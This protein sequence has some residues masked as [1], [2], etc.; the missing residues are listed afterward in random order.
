MTDEPAAST[1]GRLVMGAQVSQAISVAAAMGSADLLSDGPPTSEELAVE[2][3]VLPG[4]STAFSARSRPSTS[5]VR[6]TT[7]ASPSRRF[8][9]RF[10]QAVTRMR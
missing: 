10:P 5:C 1:L 2:T 4:R 7:G 6:T 9:R 8:A 3:G